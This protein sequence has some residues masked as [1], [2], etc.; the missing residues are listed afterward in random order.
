[1]KKDSCDAT[2]WSG[3]LDRHY[4]VDLA[5]GLSLAT[6]AEWVM[7]VWESGPGGQVS[8]KEGLPEEMP[9]IV[10]EKEGFLKDAPCP[11]TL[12]EDWECEGQVKVPEKNLGNLR[13]L[14]FSLEEAPVQDRSFQ[15]L[16]LGENYVLGSNLHAFPEISR[17]EYFCTD[18]QVT[19][20]EH[21]SSL[22]SQQT[23]SAGKEPCDS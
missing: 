17:K 14:E 3:D 20:S 10:M 23:G 16:R 8:L 7:V 9:S 13:Q 19:S 6:H 18:S 2:E 1:M 22:V 11:T 5:P 21:N 15:S 4:S 12:K